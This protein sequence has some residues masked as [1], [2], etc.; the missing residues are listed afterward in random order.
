M[1]LHPL[2]GD[3]NRSISYTIHNATL[4]ELRIMKRLILLCLLCA[5]LL[6]L[7][8]VSAS[9]KISRIGEYRGYSSTVYFEWVRSSEYVAMRDGTRIAVDVLRPAVNGLP[10][11]TPLP[12]VWA[13]DRYG[14]AAKNEQG[15]IST[16]FA[17]MPFTEVLLMYGYVVV[18]ADLRGT[19]A[20]FGNRPTEFNDDMTAEHD[21]YDMID[22]LSK[23]PWS[24]GNI[25]MVG[26]SYLGRMQ[27]W[28]AASGHPALK[29][30]IPIMTPTD[31]YDTFTYPGGAFLSAIP[32]EWGREI[33]EADRKVGLPVDADTNGAL[34]QAAAQEHAQ[35]ADFYRQLQNAPYRDS[36]IA[37]SKTYADYSM[38]PL[39]G[40]IGGVAVYQIA[41]WFDLYPKTQ[42][43]WHR[44]LRTPRRIAFTPF[45]HTAGMSASW[46]RFITP[47]VEDDF[48]MVDVVTFL[49]AEHLRFFDYHLK[50]IDNGI[51]DE[52]PVWYYLM[53]APRG[54]A[55]R[56]AEQFPL[57]NEV[58]TR[59]YLTEGQL[60]EVAPSFEIGSD[61]YMVDYST[62][63]GRTARWSD[64]TNF[65]ITGLDTLNALTY[66]SEPFAQDTEITGFP[67]VHLW[68]SANAPDVD[69]F[70]VLSEVDANGGVHFVTNGVLRASHRTLSETP[71][72][73]LGLPYR[74]S[75]EADI[76]PLPIGQP[77]E[78]VFDL[79]PTSRLVSAGNRAQIMIMNADAD[80]FV[81]NPISPAPEIT[82]YRNAVYSSYIELPLIPA[83]R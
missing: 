43:I 56:S 67:V 72:D 9:D 32:R 40:R 37:D 36:V 5:C 15:A 80:S 3:P 64:N 35:N 14:R 49:T 54:E 4:T 20:S 65:N 46:Q 75:F 47:L 38:S 74:R 17:K 31:I 53:G 27:F 50:G 10:V 68:V 82:V 63:L 7:T 8:V 42:A 48:G 22:W 69:F 76:L 30:I 39:W 79:L 21:A 45:N 51:M 13:F 34:A 16:V 73:H 83:Q 77:T 11:E 81:T 1:H 60:S 41:G 6:P 26:I 2:S 23:Q 12:V 66:T 70:V 28:A 61:S 52:A 29:A 24:D 58:R 55:W 78:L 18:S 33:L 59:F 44:N 57:S 71:Y 19:G 25:G 62:T